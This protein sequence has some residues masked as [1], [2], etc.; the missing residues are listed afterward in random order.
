MDDINDIGIVLGFDGKT[1]RGKMRYLRSAE[2]LELRG[3]WSGGRFQLDEVD[4]FGNITGKLEGSINSNILQAA[5]SNVDNTIGRK[6]MLAEV[7]KVDNLP[8]HCGDNKWLR[9]YK[10]ADKGNEMELLL[11]K[12]S[13]NQV[14]GIAYYLNRSFKVQGQIDSLN[15]LDLSLRK[16]SNNHLGNIRAAD[17]IG[18]KNFTAVFSRND[19]HEQ[20]F[21]FQLTG[22]LAMDCLEF[23]DYVSNYDIVFPKT[24]NA[25][26]NE[27]MGT[28][29][30]EWAASCRLQAK[31]NEIGQTPA[32]RASQSAS[33]WC[34]IEYFT[35]DLIS[36]FISGRTSWKRGQQDFSFNFDL[37]KGVEIRPKDI[38]KDLFDPSSFVQTIVKSA[39]KKHALYESDEGFR[40][41]I[42]SAAFPFYTI[43][44]E[45]ICFSTEFNIL[46]G[47]QSMTV[48]YSELKP[49]L[50]ENSPLKG[51]VMQ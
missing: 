19:N 46:Y 47:R 31:R 15:Y 36:G 8:T 16:A 39:F 2:T 43:R 29:A 33:G 32:T 9:F 23:A 35:D 51:L 49:Y 5:W 37:K 34:E 38:F 25:P 42:D 21:Y 48:P 50:K 22:Q 27:W 20:T 12:G 10:A 17:F 6:V 24:T 11:Q 44:K 13:N 30:A 7:A 26:F 45:G 40:K 28:K 18:S 41:W 4:S 14:W 3:T 1:C